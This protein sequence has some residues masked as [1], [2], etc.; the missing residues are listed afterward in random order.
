VVRGGDV[1]KGRF[2]GIKNQYPICGSTQ[3]SD[4][5]DTNTALNKK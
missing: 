4:S 1:N 5:A 2:H 3:L